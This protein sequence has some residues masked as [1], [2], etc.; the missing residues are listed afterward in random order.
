[1]NRPGTVVEVGRSTPPVLV[2]NGDSVVL[3]RF[4]VGTRVVYPPDPITGL[5]DPDGAIRRALLNPLDSEPLPALL[6]AGMR[7]TIAV[8][9][10]SLPLPPMRWPD[11]RSRVLEAVLDMAADAGV[12]DV[13]IIIATSLHRRM[14]AAEVLHAMGRRVFDA[15]WPDRLYNF[16]AEDPEALVE[17]GTT[18]EDEVVEISKRA[19]TSDLLVYVNI[20]LVAMDGG[21]KSVAVGL[22][23]YRSLRHHHNVHTLRHTRSLMDPPRSALHRSCTRMGRL[24]ETQVKVF[25]I[26]TTLNNDTFPAA[27]GFLNRRES[28]WTV[29]DRAMARVVARATASMPPAQARA[30]FQRTRAPYA[31]TGVFAGATEPV[32]AR[33][34]ESLYRQQAVPVRGQSDVLSVG[35][36]Y[37]GPYNVNSIMNPVLVYCMGL[38]YF[39]N[40]YRGMPLV[41]RGGVL[42]MTHPCREEFHP[43]HHP[44]Y[45]DFYEQVLSETRDP[46]RI[47]VEYEERFASDA[48]YRQLYRRSHAYHG[49]HPFYMWYWGAHALEHLGDVVVVGGDRGVCERLGFRAAST[50]DDALEMATQ[51]V[52]QHPSVTHLHCPPLFVCDVEAGG[53]EAGAP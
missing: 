14:T 41:R 18:D 37:V 3:Q 20:N 42:I 51:T 17:L 45:I 53:F 28:E 13:E 21:H 46:E 49:V 11:V 12:E 25:K 40:L 34:L 7:L 16:D 47:E 38:G 22:A 52:G 44:S 31:L 30:V 48:W 29:K 1:M 24:L 33:A 8:D 10:I 6:H 5:R 50:L 27:L 23:P 19:A 15:F 36:P 35:I 26:E 9:D 2:H 4:P 32:H 39:F 43:V